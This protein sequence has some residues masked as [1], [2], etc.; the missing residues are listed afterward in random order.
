MLLLQAN[1]R[2]PCLS[3]AASIKNCKP[4][5]RSSMKKIG[6][7][8][9]FR[10]SSGIVAALALAVSGCAIKL[11]SSYDE[12]TDRTVTALQKKMEA[13]LVALEEEAC[14][15]RFLFD[16]LPSIDAGLIFRLAWR[17]MLSNG[18]WC[19]FMEGFFHE[20]LATPKRC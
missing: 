15:S 2:L 4:V 18:F 9:S 6:S 17:I 12:T 14:Q 19:L 13:H 8:S 10:P 16:G 7:L 11:V 5:L 3:E 20:Q 1:S